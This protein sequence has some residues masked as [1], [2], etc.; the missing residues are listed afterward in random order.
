MKRVW[1]GSLGAAA[2]LPIGWVGRGYF[3]KSPVIA[4]A[5]PE[6]TKVSALGRLE[7]ASE[8]VNVSIPG[9][10][11]NDR[12]AELKVKRG[13]WLE[14]GGVVARLASHSRM[15]AARDRAVRQVEVAKARLRQVEAGAKTGEILAQ[16]AEIRRLEAQL[17]GELAEQR[18]TQARLM[19]EVKNAQMEYD[20][21]R[22]LLNEGVISPAVMDNRLLN[23]QTAQANLQQAKSAQQKIIQTMEAAITEARATKNRIAE[24]RPVD[25]A[26]AQA[27]L[28]EALATLRQAEADL[29]LTTIKAPISGA[30]LEVY[31]YP[32]EGVKDEGIVAMG[33]TDRMLA[34]AEVYQSDIGR[35]SLGQT[36][37]VTGQAFKGAIEGKVSEI[38]LQVSRQSILSTQPGENLDRRVVEVK[39]ALSPPSSQKVKHLTNHQVFVTIEP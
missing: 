10:L 12:V 7:P 27:E 15:V 4:S 2:L 9:F 31:S 33:S 22:A 20:R 21:N 35:V 1:L 8:V 18:A 34:V 11:S 30:I 6:S 13:D 17:A 38:G 25:L 28:Q 14:K 5:P 36:A 32:G 37:V 3:I 29:A 26:V 23:L 24:V 16:A 39:I 19:A